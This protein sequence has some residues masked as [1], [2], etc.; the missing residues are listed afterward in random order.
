MFQKYKMFSANYCS[1]SFII[2]N[3]IISYLTFRN[4]FKNL[5]MSLF[6]NNERLMSLKNMPCEMELLVT[7]RR[8]EK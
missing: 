8:L 2:V 6:I 5:S 4:V 3:I 1:F 7:K